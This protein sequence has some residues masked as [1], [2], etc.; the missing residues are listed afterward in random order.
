MKKHFVTYEQSKNLRRLDFK[1][2]CLGYYDQ[3]GKI[4]DFTTYKEFS[5]DLVL[6]PT[7]SQ[8]LEWF[9]MNHNLYVETGIDKT[10]EPKFWFKIN[11]FKGDPKNLASSEWGWEDEIHTS[12]FLYYTRSECESACIDKLIEI[13]NVESNTDDYGF[14]SISERIPEKGKDIL[15]IDSKGVE[16]VC[17]RCACKDP[18]CL[19]FRCTITGSALIIGVE[20]WKYI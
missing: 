9:E 11:K 2:D 7:R 20:E 3:S 5:P 8:V 18:Y 19:E 13:S 1:D 16:R 17:F 4:H 14:I 6:A 12:E 10:M 15:T